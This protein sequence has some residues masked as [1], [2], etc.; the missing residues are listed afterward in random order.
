MLKTEH[1]YKL[2]L[3]TCLLISFHT[4]AKELTVGFGQNRS[5]FVIDKSGKGLEID[6]FR[7]AL[8]HK[9]HTLTVEHFSN[10]RLA[11]VLEKIP[12]IDAV[13]AVQAKPGDKFHYVPK[14]MVYDNFAISRK[15]DKLKIK[16]IADL[17]GHSIVTWQNA[18]R[19]LG[20]EY[21]QLFNPK[22]NEAYKL[23]YQEL[24]SQRTQNI[25]FWRNG[26][27][28]IIIDKTIFLWHKKQLSDVLDTSA[29]LVYHPIF[30]GKTFFH[31][32]FR[33]PQIAKDFEEGLKHLKETGR[34]D[35]LYRKYTE[36]S[37]KAP[38]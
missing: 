30:S 38:K 7:E 37:T 6:V 10:K 15:K 34:Y 20:P 5:P 35:E 18:Y 33:D 16:T 19:D 1:L 14:Y 27:Q 26:A 8:A 23:R 29:E 24:V 21:N 22:G 4:S 36:F 13:A 25:T 2:L 28:V 31:A 17:K 3:A 11:V 9:G 12:R 32:G